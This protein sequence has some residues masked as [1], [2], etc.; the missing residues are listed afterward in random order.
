MI[1]SPV[2]VNAL[3]AYAQLGPDKVELSSTSMVFP[4]EA[5][6]AGEDSRVSASAAA[7]NHAKILLVNRFFVI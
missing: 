3:F 6:N 5:E 2:T 4:N 7:H 1:T